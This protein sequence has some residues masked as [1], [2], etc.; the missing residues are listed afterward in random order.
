M[1]KEEKRNKSLYLQVLLAALEMV[2]EAGFQMGL[3]KLLHQHKKIIKKKSL[4]Q[5]I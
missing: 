5:E 4:K 2:C 3:H 1:V